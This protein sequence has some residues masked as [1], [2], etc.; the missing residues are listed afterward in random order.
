[1]E[2]LPP[3]LS[4]EAAQELIADFKT[5]YP[6]E[7]L[8]EDT[9]PSIRLLSLVQHSLKPGEKNPLDSLAIPPQL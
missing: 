7:L 2:N 8:D 5:N 4:Q 3:K 6:G 9:M 1:M